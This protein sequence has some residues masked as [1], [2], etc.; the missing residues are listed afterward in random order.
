MSRLPG[1]GECNPRHSYN[2]PSLC[3]DLAL[4]DSYQAS[5]SD[6]MSNLQASNLFSVQGRVVVITGGGSGKPD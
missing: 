3:I 2:L 4:S 5:S 1:G 6:T